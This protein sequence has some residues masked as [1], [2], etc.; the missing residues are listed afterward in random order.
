MFEEVIENDKRR[1]S[2]HQYF[3]EWCKG[4]PACFDTC[5]YL[6]RSAVDDLGDILE[7]NAL[8]RSK[9]TEAQAAEILTRSIF[10][11]IYKVVRKG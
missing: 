10:R 7:Q 11:E 2:V 5:Y 6:N 4:L 3:E 8:E 9:Y 1:L